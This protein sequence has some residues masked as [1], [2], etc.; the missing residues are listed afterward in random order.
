MVLGLLF[1][2]AQV[3]ASNM[4]R[5]ILVPIRSIHLMLGLAGV[6]A[7]LALGTVAAVTSGIRVLG[8]GSMIYAFVVPALGMTQARLL[9]GDRHWLVQVAHLL[10]GIG[11]MYLARGI[12]K[13]YVGLRVS[14]GGA[15][16]REARVLQ[17]GR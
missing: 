6:L 3:S 14:G 11:A 5:D 13:G 4:L 1:W 7:L 9:V 12:E 16:G 17:A 8:V 15:T 10:V 2:I